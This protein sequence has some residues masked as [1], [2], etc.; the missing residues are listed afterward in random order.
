MLPR[1]LCAG[2]VGCAAL[3]CA[4]APAVDAVRAAPAADVAQRGVPWSQLTAEQR[5]ALS[6]LA[7]DW[8]GFDAPRKRKWLEIAAR[9]KDLSPEGQQKLH[10]R[11]PELAKL[12]PEQR[13]TARENFKKAYALPPEKRRVLTQQFEELP[14][15][16][17]RALAENANKK[18][19]S[20]P[21][22]PGARDASKH[23]GPGAEPARQNLEPA[24]AA[25]PAA[26]GAPAA[27]P[28]EAAVTSGR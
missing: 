27:L 20:A 22:H 3:I 25:M 6:P 18:P 28:A 7:G 4:P 23:T 15:E 8:N 12:T 16:E 17:K 11:M 26:G 21:R 10:E 19:A 14:E 9:Y 1:L 13:K 2:L 5:E 24:P